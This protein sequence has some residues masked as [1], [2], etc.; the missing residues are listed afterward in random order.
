MKYAIEERL[1]KH[2]FFRVVDAMPATIVTSCISVYLSSLFCVFLVFG[3][4]ICNNEL[5][6]SISFLVWFAPMRGILFSFKLGALSGLIACPLI[7]CA[8]DIIVKNRPPFKQLAIITAS[9]II[10]NIAIVTSLI[11]VSH[12]KIGLADLAGLAILG[13]ASGIIGIVMYN[14]FKTKIK[15]FEV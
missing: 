14:Y 4:K 9:I 12:F 6:T 5:I 3:W 7:I 8:N 10:G 2:L 13:S 11:V 1:K 15:I